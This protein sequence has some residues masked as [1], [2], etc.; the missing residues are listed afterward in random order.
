MAPGG[1][2]GCVGRLEDEKTHKVMLRSD[3]VFVPSGCPMSDA[4]TPIKQNQEIG[5]QPSGIG[6]LK[7]MRECQMERSPINSIQ[8]HRSS[9]CMCKAGSDVTSDNENT[10]IK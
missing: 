8:R 5:E 1:L 9:H 7:K 2:T 10:T 4:T 3:P 6:I